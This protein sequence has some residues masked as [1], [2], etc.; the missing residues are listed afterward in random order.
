MHLRLRNSGTDDRCIPATT[1]G[2]LGPSPR[3][4]LLQRESHEA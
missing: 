3:V 2:N 4:D 1:E